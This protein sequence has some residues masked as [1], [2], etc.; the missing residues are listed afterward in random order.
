M[1]PLI[2]IPCLTPLA[3]QEDEEEQVDWNEFIE[4]DKND[5]QDEED[6]SITTEHMKGFR[7]IGG[8]EEKWEKVGK[9][10]GDLFRLI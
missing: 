4:E 9:M 8:V 1:K 5:H 3:P 7:M 6:P 2:L 10:S